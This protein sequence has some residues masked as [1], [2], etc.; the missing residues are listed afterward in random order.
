MFKEQAHEI[1]CSIVTP[2]KVLKA[3]GH[4]DKFSDAMVKDVKSGEP[5]RV[6][7]LLKSELENKVKSEKITNILKKLENNLLKLDEIDEVI[8]E[9]D[10]RSPQTGNKL[11]KTEPFNLMFQT[12]VGP[13][14]QYKRFF[15]KL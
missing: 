14:G 10:I 3:S 9:F 4:L 13:Y 11:S 8:E 7:H 6:D 1:D 2:E 5:F 12:N 15:S